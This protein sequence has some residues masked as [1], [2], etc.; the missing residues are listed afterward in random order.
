[1]PHLKTNCTWGKHDTLLS[2]EMP[3]SS[4]QHKRQK[5]CIKIKY[6]ILERWFHI[7][8]HSPHYIIIRKIILIKHQHI[9]YFNR[10]LILFADLKNEQILII[11]VTS[12]LKIKTQ[13]YISYPWESTIELSKSRKTKPIIWFAFG[14]CYSIAIGWLAA[15]Q[16]C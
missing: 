13:N 8:W 7:R 11:L 10:F 9:L 15:S 14:V 16:K 1:M 12:F 3:N 4:L 6:R 2:N 5:G